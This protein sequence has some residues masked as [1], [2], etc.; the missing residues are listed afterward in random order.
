[1]ASRAP[2]RGRA[3]E[4][5]RLDE[6]LSGVRAGGSQVLVL[7][8]EAGAGKTALLEHLLDRSDGLRVLRVDGVQSDI[9]LPFAGLQQLCAPLA[10][11]LDRLPDPQRRALEVAFGRCSGDSPDRFL[12]GLAVLSLLSAAA[13]DAPVLAVVD[14]AQWLD[15]VSAHTLAFVARRLLA[16][17]VALV[18]AVRDRPE[19][20]AGLPELVVG[21]LSDADARELLESV[22]PGAVDPLVRD[23]IVAE[24]RGLPLAILE[25]PRSTSAAELSGGFWISGKRSSAAAIEQTYVR[26]IRELPAPTQQLL[27]LAAAEPVGDSSLFLRAAARLAIPVTELAAAEDADLIEFG[28]RMRFRHPLI[29]SAAYRA[30]EPAQRRAVHA[31]LAESTDPELDPDRRAWH[32]TLAAAGPDDALATDLERSAHRARRR[33]GLAAAAMFLEQAAAMTAEET[34]RGPRALAAARAK[35]DAG[36]PS[37]ADALLTTAELAGLSDVDAAHALRL[38]AQ[39]QFVRARSGEPGAPEV[40]D[41]A[42]GLLEAGRRLEGRDDSS[43]RECYLEAIAALV[44]AGRR[45]DPAVI[46]AAGEVALAATATADRQSRPVDLLLRGI[47]RRITGGPGSGRADLRAAVDAMCAQAEAADG[48]VGRWLSVPGFPI[49]QE[50]AAHGLWDEAAVRRLSTAAVRQARDTGALAALPR[51]L[52]FRAGAHLVAGE[53]D[54]AEQLLAEAASITE[55]TGQSSPARYHL[56]LLAAWRGDETAAELL[57]ATTRDGAARGEGRLTGLTGYAAAVLYNGLGRYDEALAAA[58]EACRYQ[59]LGFHGW[60]LYELIEAATRVGDREAAAEALTA[61]QAYLCGADTDWSAGALASAEA[62]LADGETADAL[63]ADAVEHLRRTE[64]AVHLARTRLVY[65]EWLRRAGRRT[66]ARKQL[67]QAHQGF[68]VMGALGYAQRA[69]RE[70]A[71]TG[72]KVRRSAAR[73]TGELTPQEAQI[74]AL[75]ADGLTNPEIG[76]QLFLSGHTVEWHLRKVFAKLGI[77]SRRQLR[78][79]SFPR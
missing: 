59:D 15:E 21:G 65:G 30:A 67:S 27:T 60:A 74:A 79:A 43:A 66:E 1:M 19:L 76:A 11:H 72:Q 63:Y 34:L 71:A 18:S 61:F 49:L 55:A 50:S 23:R 28:P 14:D 35:H 13:E 78:T 5:A 44:Y 8:G 17:P 77:S 42:A 9:E 29:R 6:V 40:G 16:E 69:R 3:A 58:Q 4:C 10:E 51:A 25:A 47:G 56:I 53:F 54:T 73:P 64:I 32:S 75:A 24:A 48:A 57:A 38:R 26:R 33:G 31:A 22:M 20:L 2:L 36:D 70:L 37:A 68:E 45:A 46:A 39:M 41:T 62:M 7:R 52:T 12:V